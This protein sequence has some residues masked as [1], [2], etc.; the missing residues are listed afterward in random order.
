M[1]EEE[2]VLNL[3][4]KQKH[5]QMPSRSRPSDPKQSV[6]ESVCGQGEGMEAPPSSRARQE[7]DSRALRV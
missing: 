3:R 6:L 5:C 2:Q 1:K 4:V 7:K